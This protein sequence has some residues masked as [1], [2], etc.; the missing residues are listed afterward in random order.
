[1]A[2]KKLLAWMTACN[3]SGVDVGK[4]ED[5]WMITFITF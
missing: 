4:V 1:M 5:R 2:A 3:E